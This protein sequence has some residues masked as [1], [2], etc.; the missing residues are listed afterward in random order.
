MRRQY[1]VIDAFT[2]ERF[3]GNPAAVVLDTDGLDDL[4]M[5]QIAAEFNL[6]ETTFVL[7]PQTAEAAVR[8]RWFTPTTEVSMCGHATIAGVHALLESS[9]F[10]L[11][12]A[13]STALGIDTLSGSLKAY[14]EAIPGK[15]PGQMIWLDLP[16]PRLENHPLDIEELS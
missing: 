7:P 1:Y 6:S 12:D 8:F 10:R 11:D 13:E 5:Q 3:A 2:R 4:E 15:V 9:R 14:V 16:S